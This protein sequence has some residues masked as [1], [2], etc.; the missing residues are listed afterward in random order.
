MTLTVATTRDELRAAQRRPGEVGLVM[1]MGALHAG[2]AALI[3]AAREQND[4]V[5]VTIFI[6]PL[7]FGPAEDFSRYPRTLEADLAVCAREG[8]DVV[9]APSA[10]QVYR[11]AGEVTV[12]P[13]PL[14]DEL[15]GAS[16]PGHFAGVLTVVQK[17]LHIVYDVERAYFGE[18]DYQQVILIGRMAR[19]LDLTPQI[20]GRPIVREADGLALSSRNRYLEPS[21]RA[22]AVALPEALRGGAA[23]AAGGAD[24]GGVLTASHAVFDSAPEVAVDYLELRSPD[25]GPAPVSGPARLLAAAKVGPVRL[26]DNIAIQLGDV[27]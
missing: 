4:T 11:G 10:E 25:L 14:G 2:H 23:A 7:Q 6:N 17:L 20:I 16:R 12:H 9:F 26:I 13:G 1:T 3:R 27:T 15:E 8:A 18:K 19:D 24:A 22:S 5:V 21:E